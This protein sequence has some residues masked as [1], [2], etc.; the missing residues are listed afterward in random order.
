MDVL[1][2]LFINITAPFVPGSSVFSLAGEKHKNQNIQ[3]TI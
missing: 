3:S 1:Q 2:E